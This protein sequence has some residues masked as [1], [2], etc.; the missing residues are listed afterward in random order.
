MV[1]EKAGGDVFKKVYPQA[2]FYMNQLMYAE[3]IGLGKMN[4]VLEVIE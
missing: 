1:V 4:Y 3:S 2:D